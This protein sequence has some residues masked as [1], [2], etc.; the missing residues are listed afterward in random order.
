MAFWVVDPP[1]EAARFP[2]SVEGSEG[3]VTR[4]ASVAA[5]LTLSE[6]GDSL[7]PAALSGDEVS[8]LPG[9]DVV[10]GLDFLAPAAAAFLI[11][12]SAR[13][14]GFL[15]SSLGACCSPLRPGLVPGGRLLSGGGALA[16]S[17]AQGHRHH[18]H[19]DDGDQCRRHR[20]KNQLS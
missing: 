18:E 17:S 15:R 1:A 16:R 4:G 7:P 20:H 5:V 6:V 8:S 10:S 14:G 9:L 13:C 19:R 12:F 11:F 3:S 2:A